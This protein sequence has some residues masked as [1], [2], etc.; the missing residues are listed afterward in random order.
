MSQNNGKCLDFICFLLF[1]HVKLHV[2]YI[3]RVING[4]IG[5]NQALVSSW[6]NDHEYESYY[7]NEEKLPNSHENEQ[8]IYTTIKGNQKQIKYA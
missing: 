3:S 4:L 1:C 2:K 8:K 5:Q 6:K 7:E